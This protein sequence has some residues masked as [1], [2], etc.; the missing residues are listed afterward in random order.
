[1][2]LLENI[3]FRIQITVDVSHKFNNAYFLIY[4]QRHRITRNKNVPS[5]EFSE[6]S[7]L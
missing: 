7:L 4:L 2:L 1:M 5:R 3:D 6:T